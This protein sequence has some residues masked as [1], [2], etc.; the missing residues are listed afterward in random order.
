MR[1]EWRATRVG[2]G[3]D[4]GERVEV[5]G[6]PAAF[7]GAD[8]VRYVAEI[9][10]P[11]D[12]GDDVAVLHLNGCY[13]HASVE[14]SG[15]VLGQAET[16]ITRD[17]YF[18]P[19]QVPFRP[20]DEVRVAVTC[21]APTDRFGGL[22]DTDRVPERASVPGIWWRADLDA[23]PLPYVE[24]V[25]V[26]PELTEDGARL[27]VRTTVV[28]DEQLEERIT[29]SLKPAG[30]LS[31]RGMMERATVETAGP[32]KTRVAHSIELQDPALWWPR[33][34][35]EQHRHTLR[36][37]LGDS[38]YAVTTG[39]R[40]LERTGDGLRVNGEPVSI[41]GVTL[42]T[43]DPAD[44]D[45]AVDC[46]ANL[47]RAQA[48]VLP[49]A[50]YEACDEAGLMVWQD[51]PLTGPDA[52][53]VD[54]GRE[55]ARSLAESYGH[56][57]SLAAVGIHDRPTTAFADGL[58][59]GFFDKLRLRWRAWQT[60]YDPEPAERVADAVPDRLPVFPAVGDP[61][62]GTAARRLFPG[63]DY[64]AAADAPSLL[65]RYPA[66]VLAAFGAGSAG[67]GEPAEAAGLEHGKLDAHVEGDDAASR[68]YQAQVLE[69]VA[70]A[71]RM[72]G[73]GAI[74]SCLRDIDAAG[75]G[76]FDAAGNAKPG[77]SALARAFEPVQA[78]L[79][80]PHGD[81]SEIVVCNDL[82]VELSAELHWT[83][84]DHAG[85]AD[86]SIPADDRWRGGPIDLPAS[87][88]S[89]TLEIQTD[90]GSV[91]NEYLIGR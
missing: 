40:A 3:S 82:P 78:F 18:A 17:A 90:A 55:L 41:R 28:A 80:A 34:H 85:G 21:E 12:P 7:A 58:G 24:R 69:T 47:V 39:I 5:P 51:L 29:Y 4:G 31:T 42:T 59:S 60:D 35:G 38:E 1:E 15:S 84:G 14:L 61:G 63:W 37:S 44:V 26:E 43:A 81:R 22:Q 48:Q 62:T 19:L 89:V 75:M 66:S 27:Q 87:G 53:G 20:T 52:F 36:V 16:P 65:D 67:V 68:A 56:H 8:A 32:G 13:A 70:A 73:V 91:V 88:E 57:P 64:A 74:A 79:V 83:A 46:N 10:D 86:L 72:R 6:R 54:R 23:K 30:D 25:T 50:V 11:R 71:A 2:A 77:Q 33:G 45:R 76:V 9:D 49:P